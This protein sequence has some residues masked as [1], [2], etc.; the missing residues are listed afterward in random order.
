MEN[1]EEVRREGRNA[2]TSFCY[3]VWPIANT[4]Q[5]YARRL[6]SLFQQ[7]TEDDHATM[8]HSI[9]CVCST[10]YTPY[11]TPYSPFVSKTRLTLDNPAP[12]C[13]RCRRNRTRRHGVWPISIDSW[14]WPLNLSLGIRHGWRWRERR[15]SSHLAYPAR[16]PPTPTSLSATC[17]LQR[18]EER[19]ERGGEGKEALPRQE[20]SLN[21]PRG[22]TAGSF[23]VPA[24]GPPTLTSSP[25]SAGSR[26]EYR[27]RSTDIV[28]QKHRRRGAK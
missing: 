19:G 13:R 18:E 7:R 20:I 9:R 2:E 28:M 6:V 10:R 5:L 25:P 12:Y 16:F 26:R 21:T 23:F 14:P 22:D 8:R 15:K 24:L 17:A 4:T 3:S 27:L 11:Y 1:T